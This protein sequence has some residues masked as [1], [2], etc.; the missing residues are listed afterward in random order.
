LLKAIEI[1]MDKELQKPFAI[2]LSYC[3]K[4]EGYGAQS[5]LGRK[6]QKSQSFIS[7]IANG[8]RDGSENTRREIA[9]YFGYNYDYFL[10]LG[11]ALLK[12]DKFGGRTALFWAG[13]KY[14]IDGM[15]PQQRVETIDRMEVDHS[16]IESF[17]SDEG[18]LSE[19]EQ[20][21]LCKAF[22]MG[23]YENFL[24]SGL[25]VLEMG[26]FD[27]KNA[28]AY[29]SLKP[30][31]KPDLKIAN[32]SENI[33]IDPDS[34][35]YEE[36]IRH[37]KHKKWARKINAL[38][39]EVESDPVHRETVERVVKAIVDQIRGRKQQDKSVNS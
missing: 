4:M 33:V 6:V 5:K 36:I 21:Q 17:L 8:L 7:E 37:F 28:E 30:S 38:L 20:R 2:A 32:D 15:N 27:P 14:L 24:C 12:A 16:R 3:L 34:T 9:K 13:L 31:L 18:T 22:A 35:S 10:E 23:S 11:A 19:D 25:H 29:K 26:L 1:F 39:L